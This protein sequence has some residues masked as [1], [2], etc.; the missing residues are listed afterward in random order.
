MPILILTATAFEQQ[1][2]R[3]AVVHPAVQTVAHR[4]W[5]RGV[6]GQIPVVLVET[7]IGQVN[8]AQALAVA[9]QHLRPDF[10]FQVGIGGAYLS[11]SLHIGDLALATE[12][13]YG[14]LGVITPD[15]W[16]PADDI[17]IP[18]LQT[19]RAYYNTYPLD[20]DLV[21][22][23]AHRLEQIGEPIATGP[24][25][26]VQ[27]C[28]GRTDVGNALAARFNAICENMEGAAAAHLCLLYDVPFLELRAISNRVENRDRNAWNIPL[29]LTRSQDAALHLISSI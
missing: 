18:V 2:L 29:A 8:T 9:L 25:V 24:F 23:A 27:Q 15:G 14:D 17:G 3:E 16:Y 12:E 1:M 20:A 5:M 21:A 19:D 26:T 10:V 22:R 4:T 13:T 6:I 7:G 28:S 11:S